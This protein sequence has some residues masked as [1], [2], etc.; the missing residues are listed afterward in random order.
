MMKKMTV[1]MMM[2][3]VAA[4]CCFAETHTHTIT[5]MSKVEK[6][7]AQYVIRNSETGAIGES[8]VYTTDEIAKQDVRTSFDVIQSCDSNGVNMAQIT[9]SATELRA[10]V[11]GR[12]YS[13]DGVSISMGGRAFGSTVSFARQTV[14]YVAAGTVVES[15]EVVWPT[16]GNL[17]QATYEACVTLTTVAL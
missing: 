9:V 7:D 11:D 16:S 12:V 6:R 10:N 5:L 8:V 1:A 15:F 14:G 3:L 4:L 13:T 17:V 2:I